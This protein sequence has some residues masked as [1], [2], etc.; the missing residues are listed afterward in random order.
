M[1]EL[2]DSGIRE[3]FSTGAVR[4]GDAASKPAYELISPMA[5]KRIAQHYANGAKK[6]AKRNWE[7]GIPMDRT[8]ASLLRHINQYR[9]GL[10]DEDHLAAIAWNAIALM[11]YEEMIARGLLPKNLMD[12]PS[13]LPYD[14]EARKNYGEIIK[15][16]EVPSILM[17]SNHDN[18]PSAQTGQQELPMEL[19]DLVKVNSKV[20]TEK[21]K[22]GIA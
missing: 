13:Y 19:Q 2:K 8:M 22:G 20:I 10:R 12:I 1:V 15:E 17:G 3:K 11:H 9:E 16:K 4:D 21:T 14:E 6:Y 18:K 5:L 7:A